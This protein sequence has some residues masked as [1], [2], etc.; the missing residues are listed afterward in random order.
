MEGSIT[1]SKHILLK[2]ML[3]DTEEGWYK[4]ESIRH[5]TLK[6]TVSISP[7]DDYQVVV[8]PPS[9][10]PSI[11]TVVTD[12]GAQSCLWGMQDFLRCGF[13]KTD[14]IPIKHSL[15]AANQIEINIA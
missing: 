7:Q 8:K 14:L 12:T 1:D 4:A 9:V 13:S 10:K 11:F 15:Y 6:L 3:F 5:P 2:H